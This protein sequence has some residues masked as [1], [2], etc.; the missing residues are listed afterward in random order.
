MASLAPT[1]HPDDFLSTQIEWV[2][3]L[4]VAPP[5]PN[6]KASGGGGDGGGSAMVIM[7][8]DEDISDQYKAPPSIDEEY[9][10]SLEKAAACGGFGGAGSGTT[11]AVARQQAMAT[12]QMRM[13][14]QRAAADSKY[15]RKKFGELR[16]RSPATQGEER[17]RLARLRPF[18]RHPG[19]AAPQAGQALG[20]VGV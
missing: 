5:L 11:T 18:A 17:R 10:T 4:L 13:V 7:I 19:T 14:A 16:V 2:A 8:D 12:A 6:S 1:A 15:G 3:T 20:G 9:K